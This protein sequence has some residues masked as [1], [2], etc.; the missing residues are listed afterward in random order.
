L[1][2]RG[3][4]IVK[5]LPK[6]ESFNAS[7][8]TN[9]MLSEVVRWSNKEPGT[10]SQKLIVHSDNARPQTARQTREFIEAYGMEQ[11]PYSPYS[12]DLAPSDFY[13][14]DYLKDRLQRQYFEDG[15]QLFN[16]IMY[17]RGQLKR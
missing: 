6:G 4:H 8:Y 13:L 15:D 7:Y 16:A 10:A 17:L 3:F 1:G 14:F 5:L 2:T 11:A 12:P 9:E